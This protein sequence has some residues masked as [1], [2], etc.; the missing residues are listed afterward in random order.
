MADIFLSYKTEDRA[1]ASDLVKVLEASGFSVWWDQR[2]G[3]G[4]MWRRE[5]TDQLERAKCVIVLWTRNSAGD[6]GRFVQEEAARAQRLGT[7]LPVKIEECDLPLGFSEIQALSLFNWSGRLDNPLL[8]K[9]VELA[10]GVIAA[11]ASPNTEESKV[12]APVQMRSER[13]SVTV[14]RAE[15]VHPTGKLDDPEYVDDFTT[16]LAEALHQVLDH[17][18]SLCQ[19]LDAGGFTCV[20]GV[21]ATDELDQVRAV[22]KALLLD[23]VLANRLGVDA[24]FGL[25]SGIAVTTPRIPGTPPRVTSNLRSKAEEML[26]DAPKGRIFIPAEMKRSLT[27]YFSTEAAGTGRYVVT[28]RTAVRDWIAAADEAAV[29]QLSGRATEL[30]QLETAIASAFQGSGQAVS[31]VGEAG[32]GKSRLLHETVSLINAR[33]FILLQTTCVAFGRAKPLGPI[34]D[35]LRQLFIP[36]GHDGAI[37][38]DVAAIGAAYPMLEPYA[39]VLA[40]LIA[41]TEGQEPLPYEQDGQSMSRANREATIAAITVAAEKHPLAIVIDDLQLADE[42]TQEIIGP[43]AEAIAYSPTLLVIGARP[44]GAPAWPPVVH[45]RQLVLPPLDARATGELLLA[46]TGASSLRAGLA[47]VI[48]GLTD[49]I[50]LFVEELARA[51]IER[52]QLRIVEGQLTLLAGADHA[53][54][55]RSLDAL[56]RARLDRLEPELRALLQMA[57]AIGRQFDWRLLSELI[58]T[59]QSPTALLGPALALGLIEQVRLLPEPVYRFRQHMI[60]L[61]AHDSMLK[62]ERRELHRRIGEYI[63]ANPGDRKDDRLEELAYHFADAEIADKAVK[64]LLA[65]GQKA[66]GWGSA[67]IAADLAA[68]ALV[69]VET[70]SGV[71]RDYD[72]L[73]MAYV[74]L[75]NAL[76]LSR[77]YFDRE[78]AVVV[79]KARALGPDVGSNRAQLAT[80]WWLWRHYYNCLMLDEAAESVRRLGALGDTMGSNGVRLAAIGAEGIIAHFRGEVE[81]SGRLLAK[82]V[83][84]WDA[85]A[86]P[87]DDGGIGLVGS[88]MAHVFLGFTRVMQCRVSEGWIAFD[89]AEGIAQAARQP[90]LELFCLSYRQMA[91]MMLNRFEDAVPLNTRA[92]NLATTHDRHSW[93]AVN[94]ILLGRLMLERG[95][96][97]G[98]SAIL[99]EMEESISIGGGTRAL[100]H[101]LS[102]LDAFR[103]GDT[104][105]I[106]TS[107]DNLAKGM[108]RTGVRLFVV[109]LALARAT[110]TW[111]E[112][113]QRAYAE[114]RAIMDQVAAT[115]ARI[116]HL[117]M[118]F[119]LAQLLLADGEADEAANIVESALAPLDPAEMAG[120]PVFERAREALHQHQINAVQPP[121]QQGAA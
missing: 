40:R 110:L 119:H 16:E 46:V 14:L 12:T 24:R 67:Q 28:G 87:V 44:S 78:L 54:S 2:I 7:Y 108:E 13:R 36:N 43:L 45:C 53:S 120:C 109:D 55:P 106:A 72:Q 89:A 60:Q 35:L 91:L 93:E 38:F 114:A 101:V 9:L 59:D 33:G 8:E 97:A 18:T 20:F 94:R 26:D 81:A 58:G 10:K 105:A 65:A 70:S 92:L 51:M 21:P 34:V 104:K 3:A 82:A 76:T 66:L 74:T 90:D 115:G 69:F 31:L 64:Y 63:E 83:S 6:L 4:E 17:R 117:R 116:G 11:P 99:R 30:G 50:P 102:L 68:R 37:S 62:R 107:A 47:K 71:Q 84:L 95:D 23:E 42:A 49:G 111:A 121:V 19:E 52:G 5:I 112:D 118:A 56:V 80:T 1:T 96:L 98:T 79:E 113:R 57:S 22:E 39:Q 61:V 100:Y 41:P 75:G 85:E 25:A 77:G 88:V 48:R 15:L 29:S 32:L 103:R 27:N 86:I 73:L